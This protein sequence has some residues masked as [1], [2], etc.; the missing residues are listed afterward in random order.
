MLALSKT[1]NSKTSNKKTATLKKQPTIKHSC[2]ESKLTCNGSSHTTLFNE[3]PEEISPYVHEKLM[4]GYNDILE[5]KFVEAEVAFAKI[6]DKFD[7]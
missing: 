7:L 5:G 1:T 6:R 2:S 3:K 4:A